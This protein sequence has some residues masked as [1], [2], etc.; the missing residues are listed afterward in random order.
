MVLL[1]KQC[2]RLKGTDWVTGKQ[3]EQGSESLHCAK[4]PDFILK[5]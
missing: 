4:T 2:Y 3:H 5:T 1:I